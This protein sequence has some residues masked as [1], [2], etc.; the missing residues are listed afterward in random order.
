[1]KRMTIALR[2]LILATCA[3]VASPS[4]ALAADAALPPVCSTA[5]PP[6]PTTEIAAADPDRFVALLYAKN[7]A[8]VALACGAWAHAIAA[9]APLPQ[10][11]TWQAM[12][13]DALA[14][15]GRPA[16]AVPPADQAYR[17]ATA[18]ATPGASAASAAPVF[19]AS[20]H[21]AAAARAA[22]VLALARHLA[23]DS[24]GAVAWSERALAH[25]ASAGVPADA[26]LHMGTHFVLRPG[27]VSKSWLLMGDGAKLSL[28]RLRGLPLGQPAL[29][30]LSA[31]E[32]GVGG[33]RA[34]GREIDGLAGALLDNGAR[35]VIASLWRV[36]D[37]STAQLMHRLYAEI[38]RAPDDVALA[39][40]R[41]QGA[42][43]R[44][45]SA[46]P[47][48]WAAFTLATAQR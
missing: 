5:P 23:A 25:F 45:G 7:P 2:A 24:A 46:H 10:R 11:L 21:E 41:A 19:P 32:T 14:M 6:A 44:A 42:A 47:Y 8:A 29:V 30:T 36:D 37:R 9:A 3:A 28:E 48:H 15:L 16:E 33:E 39:L 22:A 27:N 4:P 12:V 40:H 34:D 43:L 1:M 26:L 38:K 20:P 13:A 17:Q 31:C 35:Q 18:A